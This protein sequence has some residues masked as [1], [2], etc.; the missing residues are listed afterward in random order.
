MEISC[1]TTDLDMIKEFKKNAVR[2]N[3]ASIK[4]VSK[5]KMLC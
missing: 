5:N 3:Y 2:L 4:T 1:Q